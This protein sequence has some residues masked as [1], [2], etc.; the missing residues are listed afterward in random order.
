MP[1]SAAR[2]LK[3][4]LRPFDGHFLAYASSKGGE[5]KG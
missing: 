1:A 4:E 3:C 2:Q 5:L